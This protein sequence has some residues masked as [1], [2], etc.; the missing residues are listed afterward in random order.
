[1][2]ITAF[3][4]IEKAHSHTER[5]WQHLALKF[6]RELQES[7]LSPVCACVDIFLGAVD[8]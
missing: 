2:W 4:G 5:S 1:M 7:F 3:L 6:L 8:V